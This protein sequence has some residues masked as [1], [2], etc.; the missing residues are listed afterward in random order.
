MPYPVKQLR[1][2]GAY[3]VQVQHFLRRVPER[4]EMIIQRIVQVKEHST[5]TVTLHF[6]SPYPYP[7]S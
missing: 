7:V 4:N 1:H 6:H 2:V 5:L 3:S